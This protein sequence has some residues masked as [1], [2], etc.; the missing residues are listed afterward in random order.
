MYHVIIIETITNNG[1]RFLKALDIHLVIIIIGTRIVNVFYTEAN[2]S[3]NSS[4]KQENTRPT[5]NNKKE[6]KKIEISL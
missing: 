5:C 6:K 1:R 4:T 3:Q 2:L